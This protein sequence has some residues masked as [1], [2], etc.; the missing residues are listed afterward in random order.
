MVKFTTSEVVFEEIP[1]EITLAINISNCPHRCPGCHSPYLR[2][3]I[4]EELTYEVID[5]LIKE[6]D[7][8]TCVSFM[9]EGNDM[10]SI[11]HF[12]EYI[13][14]EYGLKIAIYSGS[15]D[16]PEE[17]WKEFDYIKLG[18][19]DD[20]KGPLN[21]STTNQRLYHNSKWF[22]NSVWV[23]GKEHRACRDI[24]SYFWKNGK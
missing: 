17:F 7:G 1:E 24:T 9:G 18:E 23:N 21:K 14:S 15:D 22:S 3:D 10:D 4:G 2:N 12:G 16:V 19:Y 8:I 5:K 6:N 13:H 11:F 20:E